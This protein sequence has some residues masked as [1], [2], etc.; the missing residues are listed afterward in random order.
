PLV[1]VTLAP[2]TADDA[3][4]ADVMQP[5]T[6]GVVADG[7]VTLTAPA[8]L[9]GAMARAT[10]AG[11]LVTGEVTCSNLSAGTYTVSRGA[12]TRTATVTDALSVTLP[13]L[14]AGD[15]VELRRSPSDRL[16]TRLR[17]GRLTLHA[18]AT[19]AQGDCQPGAAF[20]YSGLVCGDDGTYATSALGFT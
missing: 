17:L 7:F 6:Y 19:S 10:C 18:D 11:D 20:V 15:A 4:E 5:L 14:K 1:P 12:D 8:T 9:P 2:L 16:V 13:A 3:I